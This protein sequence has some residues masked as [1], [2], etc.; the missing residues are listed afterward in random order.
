MDVKRVDSKSAW[1]TRPLRVSKCQGG[2]T[3][4]KAEEQSIIL[5]RHCK[6]SLD[7]PRRIPCY[8]HTPGQ[9]HHSRCHA[10]LPCLENRNEDLSSSFKY[11]VPQTALRN[12]DLSLESP[13]SKAEGDRW[14]IKAGESGLS[15]CFR[16][17][18]LVFEVLGSR[19]RR[20]TVSDSGAECGADG[21]GWK[22]LSSN[23]APILSST[24]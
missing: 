7:M 13:I 23:R 19:K 15:P 1:N 10:A 3:Y 22:Y 18:E 5:H 8:L 16:I 6:D 24:E 12:V 4:I 11:T 9:A 21:T 14:R 2:H 20:G 17:Y